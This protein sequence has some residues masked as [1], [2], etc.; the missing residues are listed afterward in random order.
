MNFSL[1]MPTRNRVNLL[2]NC[3]NSF[4]QKAAFPDL[5]EFWFAFDIDD[6]SNNELDDFIGNKQNINYIKVPR[7]NW[8]HRDYHNRLIKLCKGKYIFGLND[9]CEIMTNHWDKIIIDSAE[10]FLSDKP[11][12]IAY[13]YCDDSTHTHRG[14]FR[15]KGCC[16]PILT[17]EATEASGCYIPDEIA[18]WGG[19]LS[20][21]T[22][23]SSLQEKRILDIQEL[24]RVEH[25]SCHNSSRQEDEFTQRNRSISNS[26]SKETIDKYIRILNEK[27]SYDK[28]VK[29]KLSEKFINLSLLNAIKTDSSIFTG[30]KFETLTVD[31][32]GAKIF[33]GIPFNIENKAIVLLGQEGNISKTYPKKVE[34][35]V[36]EKISKIHLLGCTAG[37]GY[38]GEGY[39][40]AYNEKTISAIVKMKYKDGSEEYFNLINGIHICDFANQSVFV[41]E[42]LVVSRTKEQYQIR[43]LNINTNKDKVLDS[44][45]IEKGN[46][47]TSPIFLSITLEK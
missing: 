29:K 23:Y 47:I 13:I 28:V 30:Q 8:F 35:D 20:L 25:Y 7:T 42:S 22:I 33:L 21:Y 26:V 43:Y 6:K 34:Y 19:D 9:E 3:I 14:H 2:K 18:M 15:N 24:V 10:S 27:I 5:I 45:S 31:V 39:P 46:D 12:R 1:I 17:K 37:W 41:P 40:N 36:K 32:A 4:S 11:D 44:F 38:Q 16:F